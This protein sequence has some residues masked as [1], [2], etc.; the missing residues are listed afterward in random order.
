MERSLFKTEF[1]KTNIP[2]WPCPTCSKGIL[3]LDQDS[4][5]ARAD[6]VT[7]QYEGCEERDYEYNTYV[8]VGFLNC[9]YCREVVAFSGTGYIDQVYEDDHPYSKS[10]YDKIF[11]PKY[12]FPALPIIQ[13]PKSKDFPADLK[14]LIRKAFELYWCDPDTCVNR[15]R[16]TVEVLLDLK[17]VLRKKNGLTGSK[18][19][20][21]QRVNQ[22]DS[23]GLEH[24]KEMMKALGW[25]GNA[26][27]HELDG[28]RHEQ[29]LDA[30]ELLQYCLNAIYP[31][32]I[33]QTPRLMRIA[34]A[35]NEMKRPVLKSE[36]GREW[37][38]K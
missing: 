1:Q 12:F 11:T 24:P 16:T 35:T 22:L 32:Q 8:F 38:P 14:E 29:I 3:K 23:P 18:F 21:E 33:D 20:F 10:T 30:F 28:I 26:G 5:K 9:N 27:T 17:G 37:I 19:T 36:L 34:E 7:L 13:L 15:I 31:E 6:G 4:F 2:D 25:M